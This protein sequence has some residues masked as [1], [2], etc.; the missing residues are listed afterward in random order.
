MYI[1]ETIR[2]KAGKAYTQHQLIKSVR[3]AAG[4]R[5]EIILNMQ[6]LDLDKS[7]WKSL[8]NAI[9]EKLLNQ[10]NLF[11]SNRKIN[12]LAEHYAAVITQNRLNEQ[13]Q[14]EQTIEPIEPEYKNVDINSVKTST[15]REF[16]GENL[17]H[18]VMQ[19]YKIDKL[20]EE[21]ELTDK[22]KHHCKMLIAG[23]ILHPGSERETA[24]WLNNDTSF[25][26]IVK[27]K[28]KI[29]DTALHRA[30]TLLLS[31]HHQIEDFLS[32]Q[33]RD[34]FSL[35]E[36][37]ILY[38]LTNTYF[39]GSKRNSQRAQRG[40]SKEK[41]TDC[42]LLSLALTIDSEG[43]PKR[44][45]IYE[46]NIS[47][48]STL[49][50][51]LSQ[52]NLDDPQERK[53]I[54]MDAGIA[55]EENLQKLKTNYDYIAVS[56]K[57]HLASEIWQSGKAEKILLKDKKTHLTI[58][59]VEIDNEIFVLC[60][61][62]AKEQKEGGIIQRRQNK[63]EK[64]LDKIQE[65]LHQSGKLKKYEKVLEKIGRLKEKYK[66]GQLYDI[67][68]SHEDG[69]TT[70]IKYA[71]NSNSEVKNAHIGE[72]ILRTNRQDLAKEEISQ[73][74]R[75][76]TMIEA[77][78]RSMKSDLGLRPIYHQNDVNSE[79]HLYIT[80]IA[81]HFVTSILKQLQ[82]NNINMTWNSIRNIL[83]SQKRVTTTFNTKEGEIINVRTNSTPNLEQ[84][85]IHQS[86]HKLKPAL[87]DTKHMIKQK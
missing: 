49:E 42:P 35:K 54:V 40:K 15:A 45:K 53:T 50:E 30:S 22:Q 79:A 17:V 82:N 31:K 68:I 41:R 21:M 71:R 33:A 4:P 81:Y 55:T 34:L 20:F 76:L 10:V 67:K 83:S 32:E 6:H 9:E 3:T 47:E 2:K 63:F 25:P 87:R 74:H 8:A 23:R 7:K 16:G 39:E 26:E 5:Q 85:K 58:K 70:S 78:F 28:G 75:S 37:I 56:R 36:K 29:Y 86:F 27:T 44:S 48:P 69:K 61:S 65:G 59:S 77:S 60:H 18:H 80:V 11:N 24:R 52:I 62:E 46:G 1:R 19:E 12:K 51:V 14:K 13:P 64:E 57:K 73:I 84:I 72:Y 66:V 43:F 38:D